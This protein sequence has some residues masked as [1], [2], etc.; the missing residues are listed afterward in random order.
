MKFNDE[1]SMLVEYIKKIEGYN[2]KLDLLNDINLVDDMIFNGINN[3]IF[4]YI[5]NKY[6]SDIEYYGSFINSRG[7][8][9]INPNYYD[10]LI[11]IK[12][13]LLIIGLRKYVIDIA[14]DKLRVIFNSSNDDIIK[15]LKTLVIR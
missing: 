11:F 7:N 2:D 6:R 13:V 10:Q 4:D 5:C 15:I 14:E 3:Q 12:F 1:L 9:G 8:I